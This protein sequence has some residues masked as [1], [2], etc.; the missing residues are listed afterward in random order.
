MAPVLLDMNDL[1]AQH[2]ERLRKQKKLNKMRHMRDCMW[3]WHIT[4]C[5]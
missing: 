1:A 3:R 4:P 5:W 2:F